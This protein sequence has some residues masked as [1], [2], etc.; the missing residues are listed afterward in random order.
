M[1]LIHIAK[2]NSMSIFQKCKKLSWAG[3][4]S[5]LISIFA[6]A[7]PYLFPGVYPKG[8]GVYYQITIPIGILAGI[9]AAI[10]RNSWLG[11]LAFFAAFSPIFT[12]WL[13]F[14]AALFLY[15]I[16]FGN[17]PAEYLI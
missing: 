4:V 14:A 16:T 8:I 5:I 2:A 12:I 11:I 3:W 1:Q 7:F 17:F 9:F 13:S 10:A 15:I 6:I